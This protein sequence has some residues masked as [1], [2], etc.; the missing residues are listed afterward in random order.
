M[1][2]GKTCRKLPKKGSKFDTMLQISKHMI[3][4]EWNLHK[5]GIIF[6][7]FFVLE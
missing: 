7:M 5:C 2:D 6:T 1:N 3:K 4:Y